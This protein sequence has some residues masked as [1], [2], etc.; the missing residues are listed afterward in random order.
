MKTIKYAIVRSSKGIIY[1]FITYR[2]KKSGHLHY[3]VYP[4]TYSFLYTLKYYVQK[5]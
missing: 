3:S 1:T 4:R 2:K 5:G